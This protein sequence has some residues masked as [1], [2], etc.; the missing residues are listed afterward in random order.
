MGMGWTNAAVSWCPASHPVGSLFI[1][2]TAVLDGS[3]NTDTISPRG[4]TMNLS[5][6]LSKATGIPWAHL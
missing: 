3:K 6:S 2:V 1:S 5:I 4:S